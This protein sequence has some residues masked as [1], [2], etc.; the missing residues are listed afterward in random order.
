MLGP[1]LK[2]KPIWPK[3]RSAQRMS[4]SHRF[5]QGANVRR[6]WSPGEHTHVGWGHTEARR[7]APSC[8]AIV[9]WL[10][11]HRPNCSQSG[12]CT[13]SGWGDAK[14]A[15]YK[16]NGATPPHNEAARGAC[17]SR[18]SVS[19]PSK[20]EFR[21]C[22]NHLRGLLHTHSGW[23]LVEI[24]MGCPCGHCGPC[25]VPG[26]TSGFLAHIMSQ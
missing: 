7:A 9:L 11:L 24:R 21:F 1:S 14:A 17:P 10:L 25:P 23:K 18:F 26:S 3:R 19:A 22:S 2:Q 6:I 4:S 16:P 12:N 20:M 13:Q 8:C 15:Q 5:E